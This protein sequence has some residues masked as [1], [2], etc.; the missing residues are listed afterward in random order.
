MQ[1]RCFG[2]SL[3]NEL[4]YVLLQCNHMNPGEQSIGHTGSQKRLKQMCYFSEEIILVLVITQK[5]Q[6]LANMVRFA[7]VIVV[8]PK[9]NQ[10]FSISR[11]LR[12]DFAESCYPGIFQDRFRL[13]FSCWNF[14]KNV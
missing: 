1:S 11:F 13:K 7:P 4:T 10:V 3:E 14:T 5:M 2:I 8:R 9:R 12:C 6:N